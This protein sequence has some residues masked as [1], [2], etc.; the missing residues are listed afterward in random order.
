MPF[1]HVIIPQGALSV[2]RKQKIVE[3]VTNALIEA[4]G[5]SEALRPG[6]TVLVSEAADGGWGIAG[7]GYTTDELRQRVAKV[8]AIE[9]AAKATL[10]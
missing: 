8:E 5:G 7:R 4:E 9:A 10:P 3:L 6:V 2:R 1:A